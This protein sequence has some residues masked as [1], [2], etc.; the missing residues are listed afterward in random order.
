MIRFPKILVCSNQIMNFCLLVINAVKMKNSVIDI[1]ILHE[2]SF[3]ATR[4][5]TYR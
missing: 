5:L 2:I 4:E 3:L 1:V